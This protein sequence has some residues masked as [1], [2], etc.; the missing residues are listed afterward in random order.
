MGFT[1]RCVRASAFFPHR[2]RHLYSI[3]F[4]SLFDSAFVWVDSTKFKVQIK[5]TMEIRLEILQPK[6]ENTVTSEAKG[7]HLYSIQFSSL[8]DSVF[9]WVDSTKF[10]VQIKITMEIRVEIL[11]PKLGNTV[12]SEAKRRHL[13]SIQF[14]SL[15]D[16]V[17]VWVDSTKFK[18]QITITMEIRL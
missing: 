13:Y 17:F 16:S 6:L 3:Q 12:T 14:S 8:F 1:D 5:I 2:W 18:V 11:Q 4:S 15:L 9:V 7:R 10:K